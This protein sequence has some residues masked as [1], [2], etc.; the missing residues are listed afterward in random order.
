LLPRFIV[1]TNVLS[2]G[3]PRWRSGVIL[4]FE[5]NRAL[6][7]A[8]MQD[9]KIFIAVSGP[10]SGRRRLLAIIRSDFDHIHRN[11]RSLQPQEMV[12]LPNYPNVV[13]A[14]SKLLAMEAAGIEMFPD[15]AEG[16][17]VQLKVSEL[18]NGVD[19]EGAR[20]RNILINEPLS[21]IQ[22]FCSYSR[23]DE[24]LRDELDTHLK[25]MQRQGLIKTWHDRN[26]DA[27]DD[28][29]QR[30]DEN[31]ER[32]DIILLLVS[33]DFIASEYCYAKEMK[34]ALERHKTGAAL[35]I[36]IILRDVNL[37]VAPFAGIQYLPKDGKA[38]MLWKNRDSAWRSVSEGIQRVAD[39]ILKEKA[40]RHQGD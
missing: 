24:S 17:V 16:S 19:L 38:I 7:K 30:I 3:L 36:P 26:I 9:K 18:L 37:S 10:P 13:I 6:V 20:L 2:E 34:R 11:I 27:G 28:W 4:K 14:Y 21:S 29:K 31:L 32:A 15:V 12:A 33:A 40:D 1:R 8:D 22:L 5:G 25:L 39:A 35:V 23:K